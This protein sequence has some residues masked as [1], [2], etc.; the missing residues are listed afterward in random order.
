[1]WIAEIAERAIMAAIAGL[2]VTFRASRVDNATDSE[3]ERK[4]YPAMVIMASGGNSESTESL[5]QEVP[6]TVQIITH[7]E[8]DPKR[9]TLAGLE[10]Q[11]RKIVNVP[12][13][14]NTIRTAFNAAAIAA[15]ETFYLKGITDIE[16]GPVEITD[17]Q[18]TIT[19]T[20][21]LRTCGS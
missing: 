5:F 3:T 19:T 11:F 12:I 8:D 10:D 17:K 14:T 4:T 1:M 21:I 13:A 2:D 9:T 20:M 7:Y 6:V 16:G 15:G 18:Q